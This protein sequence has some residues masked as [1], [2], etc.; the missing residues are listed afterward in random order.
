MQCVNCNSKWETDEKIAASIKKC[1]FCGENPLIKKE[2]P[3]FY[4]T[5]RETLAAI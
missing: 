1:P 3:K 5:S 4:E 2:E